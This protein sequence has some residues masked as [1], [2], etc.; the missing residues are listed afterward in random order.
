MIG[1]LAAVGKIPELKK[2][3]LFTLLLL[4]V[5]RLGVHVSTPGIDIEALQKM[6]EAQKGT[7]LG[8]IN[9]FSGGALEQFSVLTLGITP[10]ISV[11]IIM[12]VL[13]PVIPTLQQLKK[14]GEAGRKIITRYTRIGTILLALLQSYFIARG[15]ENQGLVLHP[16]LTFQITAV[17]TL[18]TGTAFMMWVGEQITEKGIGDGISM[19]IFAGIVAR[20][21]EVLLSTIEL[22]RSGEIQP[23]SVLLLFTGAILTVIAIVYVERSFRKVP[24]QYPKR[25][26]GKAMTQAQTQYMPLKINM[27]GV[28]PPIFA[29]A[30]IVLPLTFASFSQNP[31][32]RE[33]TAYLQHGTW[34]YSAVFAVLIALFSFFY[35]AVI[36]NPEEVADNLKKNGGFIPS[37]RPGKPTADYFYSLLNRLTLWGALYI[38]LICLVPEAIYMAL[39]A[40]QFAYVFGGTAILIVVGVTLDTASQIQT[41]FVQRNYDAFMKKAEAGDTAPMFNGGGKSR[42]IRR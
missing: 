8:L 6:F 11:S 19:L 13:T 7:L 41:Y 18:T 34:T 27:S 14:E 5:Y 17:I 10:Y 42:L 28:I 32:I 21:P 30:L 36:F 29:S 2:R 15:L 1:Q 33:L 12:Q 24:V 23:M 31:K 39:G 4:A 38:T 16:G 25:M 22:A 9:L 20:M 40:P 37:V 35:V 3:I 26:V